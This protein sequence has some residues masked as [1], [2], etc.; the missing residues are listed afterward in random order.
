MSNQHDQYKHKWD[1]FF[2]NNDFIL[3]SDH[4]HDIV[5]GKHFQLDLCIYMTL[6]RG[7]VKVYYFT[8]LLFGDCIMLMDSLCSRECLGFHI[9]QQPFSFILI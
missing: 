8:L 9:S 3:I 4:G 2:V 6:S 7:I 5:E 1:V